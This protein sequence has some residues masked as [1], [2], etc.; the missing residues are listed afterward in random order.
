MPRVYSIPPGVQFL[1]TLADALLSGALVPGY[2]Y[3]GDPLS[4]ADVTIY[5]PTRR[6]ARELRSVFVERLDGN[7][8][9]LPVIRPL[10]EFS[11]E[12]ADL[13]A[14]GGAAAAFGCAISCHGAITLCVMLYSAPGSLPGRATHAGMAVPRAKF[15]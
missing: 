12:L 13:E 4:L 14:E 10:G 15:L 6:A 8:A 3:E 2:R 5:L 1:P 9:I 7:S 11:V